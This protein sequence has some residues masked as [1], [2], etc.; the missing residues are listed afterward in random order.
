MNNYML[1][2]YYKNDK[3][4][5]KLLSKRQLHSIENRQLQ[6]LR[7]NNYSEIMDAKVKVLSIIDKDGLDNDEPKARLDTAIK[8]LPYIMPTKKA[9]EMTVTARKLED[10]ITESIEEAQI[11]DSQPA[12][13]DK[14]KENNA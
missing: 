13:I 5:G 4:K 3:N 8:V 7:Q 2:T 9:I 12:T 1:M 10:I 11:I 14:D 6:A